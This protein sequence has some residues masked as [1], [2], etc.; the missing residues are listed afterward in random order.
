MQRS[1]VSH[2]KSICGYGSASQLERD[3]EGVM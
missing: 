1:V 2:V 3:Q